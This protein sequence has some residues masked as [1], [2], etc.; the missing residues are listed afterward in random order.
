MQNNSVGKAI[1]SMVLG[2]LSLVLC[3]VP[4]LGL[5]LALVGLPLGVSAM[6]GL[7]AGQSGRGMAIAGVTMGIIGLVIGL[8]WFVGIACISVFGM[9]DITSM[10]DIANYAGSY[11]YPYASSDFTWSVA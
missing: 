10:A 6:R 8:L 2:I 7:P 4:V 3:Y 5:I 1:A 11:Y 9:A